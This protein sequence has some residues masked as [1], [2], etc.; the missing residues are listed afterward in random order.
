[1]PRYC[2]ICEEEF[3][4]AAKLAEHLKLSECSN[5]V[6]SIK[7]PYCAREDFV[8]ED[9]LHR[10]L[11]HNR[12]CSRADYE[13]NDKLSI[14]APDPFYS[15]LHNKGREILGQCPAQQNISYIH[16]VSGLEGNLV[17][18][19]NVMAMQAMHHMNTSLHPDSNAMTFVVKLAEDFC[20]EDGTKKPKS[21]EG[22]TCPSYSVDVQ[23]LQNEISAESERHLDIQIDDI[24][25]ESSDSSGDSLNADDNDDSIENQNVQ[26][27]VGDDEASTSDNNADVPPMENAPAQVN[28]PNNPHTEAEKDRPIVRQ[29]QGGSPQLDCLAELYSMLDKRGVANSLFD[30][31]VN[32]AWLHGPSFG[33]N[34]PMKRKTVVEKV[35]QH[36][37][38]DNYREYMSP[39]QKVLK[40]S[41]GRHVAVTYFPLDSMIKDLLCNTTLMRH[42]N[43]LIADIHN[44]L[45][46]NNAEAMCFGEVDS[47]SWWR[48]A[49]ENDCVAPNDML[50]PLIMFIDGMKVDNIAGKLKLEPITFTFSRFRRWVRNQDNAW[51]TWAYME[52]VKEPL[53]PND[54]NAIGLT[55]KDRLQEYHDILGFLMKDLKKI[56]GE[57]LPWTLDFGDDVK[58]NVVLRTPLQLVIG[59]CE[60]HDKLVGRF[61]GHTQNIKGLCRDC[62]IP[63]KNS[64]DE[65]W[66]CTYFDGDVMEQLSAEQ[67]RE[68]SFHKINNG[69]H[70]VSVG[71]CPRGI[72]TLFNPENLHLYQSGHC[73][74]VS[75]GFTFTLSSKALD[76]TKTASIF[77]VIMNR[78]Q[79]DRNY[80]DLGTF[81]DGLIKP[82]GTNLQGHEKHERVFFMYLL[83]CCSDYM[84]M[85]ASHPKRGFHYNVQFY[86]RYVLMLEHCLGFQ[87]WSTQRRHSFDTVIGPDGTPESS[88]AQL[89]VRRYLSLL[90]TCCPREELG[91]NYKMTKFHQTLHLPSAITRHGSLMN[92]D[93]SWPESM[94]KGNV[95]DPANHTQRVAATLSYQTGKRYIESLTFRE[96]KRLKAEVNNDPADT[97]IGPGGYINNCTN[98]AALCRQSDTALPNPNDEVS[99]VASGT[100]FTLVLD[101][102][103]QENEYIVD[104]QWGGKGKQTLGRFDAHL[105]ERLAKRLFGADDGGIV[106]DNE[107]V[108]CT[109]VKVN[110]VKY[111]AHPLFRNEHPWHDWVYINWEGY[112]APYPARIDMFIDLR[113]ANIS[114]IRA[115]TGDN[116]DDSGTAHAQHGFQHIFLEQK[117]YAV[118]WSAKSLDMSRD[119]TTEHHTPLNLAYRVEL[120]GYRR[121]VAVDTFVKPCFAVL[122]TCGISRQ[123][124][125]GT[126]IVMK[127][128][129]D[130]VQHFLS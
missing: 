100:K 91:K 110:G 38:G 6:A 116:D 103:R 97:S 75:D 9:S 73:E 72:R 27:E 88:K 105:L 99:V 64:D 111:V 89:S 43:L 109:C 112:D 63:T 117:L 66:V 16:A 5:H 42:E 124:F 120:E 33:R 78:G 93:G 21:S 130:W 90:K 84:S 85:L 81:R 12:R 24:S 87:E 34:P 60:G 40:L 69:F 18:I 22:N 48:T 98:E 80:P 23:I 29:F 76:Y 8:D 96:Y 46:D 30:D 92:L 39:K 114:D 58:H 115:T 65:N 19:A 44:P 83:L 3:P 50:W 68:C 62:D 101:L 55:A 123:P 61:K 25:H 52:E 14:L 108:G 86:R 56:Q 20:T 128:R 37:R 121:I 4:T 13:A 45:M 36:V 79:S 35:F 127:D 95:K 31:I 104:T 32:W 59:D 57:G 113:N 26:F 47:G 77:L 2:K 70:G 49:K 17:N 94:A 71:G 54:D 119:K 129:A 41:T 51:R 118:V 1:M 125:D 74:W 15:K 106:L 11:S 7:C 53:L 102:D 10:H 67:L 28:I 107:V 126:A 122:N 82:Q